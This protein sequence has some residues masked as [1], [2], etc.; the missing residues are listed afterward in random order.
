MRIVLI[1]LAIGCCLVAAAPTT[2]EPLPLIGSVGPGFGI[3]VTDSNG[4]ALKHLDPGTYVLLVHDLS[5]EHNFHLSGPGVD[6]ATDVT[7]VG[8][9][10]FT[11]TVTDGTYN[12]V[13]DVHASRMH[14]LFT[15]GAT[16]PP[17][18]TTTPAPAARSLTFRVGPGR[19]LAAPA[20]LSAGSYAIT[21]R[22]AS[23]ADNLHVKGKGVDRKT[24]IAFKGQAHWA[25]TLKAGSYR[26]FSDAHPGLT[27]TI[28]VA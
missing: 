28:R 1:A 21:V 13:C 25:V 27:R 9:K 12:F 15:V 8:D 2:A 22:D 10:T 18:T 6:V 19:A 17:A 20:R 23:A 26:V 11:I 7:F 5:E 16:P 4:A 24:G 14:G 3:S